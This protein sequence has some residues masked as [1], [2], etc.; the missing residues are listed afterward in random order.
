MMRSFITTLINAWDPMTLQPGRLAP[1]DEYDLEIKKIMRFLQT[2]EKLDETTLSDAISHIFHRS[3]SGCYASREE[4]RIARE[5]LRH[6]QARDDA[7]AV[8]NKERA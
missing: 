4:R 5:I 8:M 7:V 1:E 3:F 2:A 6:L